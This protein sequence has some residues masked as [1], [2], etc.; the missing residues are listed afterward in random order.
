MEAEWWKF[1][2]R[3]RRNN[4]KGEKKNPKN[5]TKT[6]KRS[7]DTSLDAL[8]KVLL[9]HLTVQWQTGESHLSIKIIV[10]KVCKMQ[11]CLL[12]SFVG[13]AYQGK[14]GYCV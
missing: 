11:P 13:L 9:P 10:H 7:P 6:K 2:H 3:N 8:G 5:K 1:G 14:E 12:S 4:N